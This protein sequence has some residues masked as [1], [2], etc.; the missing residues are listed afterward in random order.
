M[1]WYIVG[2]NYDEAANDDGIIHNY[3]YFGLG[4]EP[5]PLRYERNNKSASQIDYEWDHN[6]TYLQTLRSDY[7]YVCT[8]FDLACRYFDVSVKIFHNTYLLQ[9]AFH[10]GQISQYD[11]VDFG[12]PEGGYSIIETELLLPS[13][14]LICKEFLNDKCLFPSVDKADQFIDLYLQD[15]PDVDF[16]D[17]YFVKKLFP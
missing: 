2:R 4:G 8:S 6:R 17:A 7:I 5:W 1:D 11:G 15:N 3:H 12:N 13:N 16:F 9:I 10:N 14:D